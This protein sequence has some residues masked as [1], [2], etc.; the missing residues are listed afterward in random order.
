MSLGNAYRL[1][2][3]ANYSNVT[4]ASLNT[5]LSNACQGNNEPSVMGSLNHLEEELNFFI[6]V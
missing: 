6:Q 3:V 1:S 2:E 4:R 5:G